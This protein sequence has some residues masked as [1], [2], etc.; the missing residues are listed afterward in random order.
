VIAAERSDQLDIDIRAHEVLGG[1]S[2]EISVPG[3]AL[4]FLAL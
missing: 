4:P 1:V 2:A 3:P